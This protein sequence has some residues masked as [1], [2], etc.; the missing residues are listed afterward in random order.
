[1]CLAFCRSV[2][3]RRRGHHHHTGTATTQRTSRYTPTPLARAY[4]LLSGPF[5]Y[6]ALFAR[7]LWWF[8]AARLS[9][10]LGWL[11][12]LIFLFPCFV[13]F[14]FSIHDDADAAGWFC[15]MLL[16][17]FTDEPALP[18]WH[19]EL[20]VGVGTTGVRA[21]CL[22]FCRSVPSRRR[23]HH[24]HTGT[25]TTQR[26]SRY[27]PTPLARAYGLLSG[28]FF[29]VALF[30][31][32]LWWFAAARLSLSLGWLCVLI[33]LFPC[34]VGFLFFRELLCSAIFS[35]PLWH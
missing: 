10:S 8:A 1:M 15:W 30:A 22:A 3:S 2:P 29:Y 21:L 4:G 6:V 5:F 34:F 11:C 18:V 26:T 24:H 14:L 35:L 9:L 31:R 33:F 16:C 27:T 28:P 12:V 17:D 20:G 23:G 25:A 7:L 19:W 13:G 32:L